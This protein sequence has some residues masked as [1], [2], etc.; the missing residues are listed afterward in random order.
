MT[1]SRSKL[2]KLGPA[3]GTPAY[4]LSMGA[5]LIEFQ[6]EMSPGEF[7]QWVNTWCPFSYEQALRPNVDTPL[8]FAVKAG[9]ISYEAAL[10]LVR[11]IKQFQRTESGVCVRPDLYDG[12]DG[13][14]NP[15]TLADTHGL[16][17]PFVPS[18]SH[19]PDRAP[20]PPSTRL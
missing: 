20:A 14:P 4:A 15:P 13:Q 16:P 5:T 9:Y 3:P 17:T 18:E 7:R 2:I 6:R 8:A 11:D 19:R 1:N 10:D 12:P